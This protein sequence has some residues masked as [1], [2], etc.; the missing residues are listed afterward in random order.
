MPAPTHTAASPLILHLLVLLLLAASMASAFFVAPVVS[1]GAAARRLAFT[2]AGRYVR[3]D[4]A[5]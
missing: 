3:I 2:P 4:F 1:P 5:F